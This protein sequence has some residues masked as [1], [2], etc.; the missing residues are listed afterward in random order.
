MSRAEIPRKRP[1]RLKVL[2]APQR[3]LWN[4][5]SATPAQFTL[6]GGT[7]LALRLGHRQSFDFDFFT[8]QPFD[9]DEIESGV[10]YLA[11]ARVVQSTKGTLTC[12][13]D[14]DGPV[15]VSFFCPSK[16]MRM[17]GTPLQVRRPRLRLAS[18]IDIAATKLAVL[19]WRAEPR[20]YL[21][22][23]ALL[24]EAEFDLAMMLAAVRFV[25]ESQDYNP[26]PTL[27]ALTYYGEDKLAALPEHVKLD[28]MDAAR[29]VALT[30][31]DKLCRQ[32][33]ANPELWKR[34]P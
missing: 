12:I 6:Y 27:K 25:F 21:D 24:T 1:L 14:R 8:S 2:D 29:A 15:Q 17:I 19:S 22:V 11:K 23:H 5:L 18:L 9:P 31:Y 28:L 10:S 4:E 34:L 13:V 30:N 16:P 26:V 3:A 33:R 20:D 7:A 32:Y